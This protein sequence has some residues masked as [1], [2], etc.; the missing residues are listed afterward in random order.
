MI[1]ES[2]VFL[3]RRRTESFITKND[4]FAL[5]MESIVFYEMIQEFND[6]KLEIEEIVAQKEATR[7]KEQLV[8]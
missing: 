8:E 5:K 4:T 2:D 1:G 6:I 7:L 3:K